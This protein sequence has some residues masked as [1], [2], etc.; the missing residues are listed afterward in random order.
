MNTFTLIQYKQA[1]C[2]PKADI[3]AATDGQVCDTGCHRFNGGRCG[4]YNNLIA[5]RDV[6]TKIETVRQEAER[7]D[8]SISQ[9]RREHKA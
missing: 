5:S 8:I 1:G 7:R 4:A 2:S 9:V 6:I 3:H